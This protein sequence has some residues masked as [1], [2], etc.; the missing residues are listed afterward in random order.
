MMRCRLL[1]LKIREIEGNN[2]EDVMLH[3]LISDHL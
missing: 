2:I 1:E 3:C